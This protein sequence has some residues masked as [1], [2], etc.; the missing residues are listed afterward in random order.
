MAYFSDSKYVKELSPKEF[1]P[2]NPTKLKDSRCS[3]VL[4][5]APWCPHCKNVKEAWNDMGKKCGT[6]LNVLA[7]DCEKYKNHYAKMREVKS[8]FGGFPTMMAF[9]NG[10]FNKQFA[11]TGEERTS[12]ALIETV[13]SFVDEQNCAKR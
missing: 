7:L 9:S 13:M 12:S 10:L 8:G 6:M 1:D 4:F 2:E 5:Y 11:T 3:V